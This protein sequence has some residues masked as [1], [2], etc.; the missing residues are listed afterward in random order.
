MI[1]I[2]RIGLLLCSAACLP[3]VSGC[4]FSIGGKSTTETACESC[5]EA[6]LN[7]LESRVQAVEQ[8]LEMSAAVQPMI[9]GQPQLPAQ[10]QL[11]SK[12][13]GG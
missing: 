1:R 13:T 6:R 11:H 4:V 9:P 2:L 12:E 8:R 5:E 10:P 3:A 7:A